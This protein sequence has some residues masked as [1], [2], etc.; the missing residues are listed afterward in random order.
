MGNIIKLHEA[1]AII[2]LHKENRTASFEEIANEIN[3]RGLYTRKDGNELPDYQV[4]MRATLA[5]KQYH[6]LFEF[7]EPDKI[8]LKNL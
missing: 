2:L 5:N 4:K 8:V 3:K 6:H 1:M 7:I